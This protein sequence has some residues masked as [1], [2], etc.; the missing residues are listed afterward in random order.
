MKFGVREIANVVFRAKSD[1]K[2]GNTLKQVSQYYTS[3][4]QKHLHLKELLQQYMLRVVEV[5]QD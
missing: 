5:M 2:I 4:Q 3:I 1:V